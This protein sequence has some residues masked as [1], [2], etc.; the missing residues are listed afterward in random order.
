MKVY[1]GPYPKAKSKAKRIVKI[2]IDHWDLWSLDDTLGYIILP[3]LKRIRAA[4]CGAPSAVF[5]FSH[6]NMKDWQSPKF[7]AAEKKSNR[8]GFKKWYGILDAMIWS[9]DQ[10]MREEADAPDIMKNKD[11]YMAYQDRM[12]NGFD[13]FG[14]WF[15]ALWT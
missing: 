7:K 4:K 3:A 6:H 14:K 10:M 5:D 2:K 13:L 11:A 1:I 9:F 8:D 15:R 12:A